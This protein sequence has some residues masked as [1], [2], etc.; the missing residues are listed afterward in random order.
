MQQSSIDLA[1]PW[2]LYN[3][4]FEL[5]Q[6]TLQSAESFEKH[7]NREMPNA[8][9]PSVS[10]APCRGVAYGTFLASRWHNAKPSRLDYKQ[11]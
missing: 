5:N 10:S 9:A 7:A 3:L 11:A 1:L 6:V 4:P 8:F 2:L